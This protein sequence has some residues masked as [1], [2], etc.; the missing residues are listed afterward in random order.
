MFIAPD[1]QLIQRLNLIGKIH[2]III[3]MYAQTAKKANYFIH[4]LVT[5]VL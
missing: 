4:L 2:M 1:Y 3:N 5:L